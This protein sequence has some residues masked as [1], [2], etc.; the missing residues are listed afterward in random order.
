LRKAQSTLEYTLVIAVFA[1]ALISMT[2]YIK[3]GFQGNYRQTADGIGSA[4][5][6]K[7][8]TSDTTF[9]SNGNSGITSNTLDVDGKYRTT[10][11]FTTDDTTWRW[12]W[13]EVGPLE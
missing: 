9:F 5:E 12:G 10:T 7:N 8:T 11:D 3:R 4:Y 6:P 1:A 13:E 2:V